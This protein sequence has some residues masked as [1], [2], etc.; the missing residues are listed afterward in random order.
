MNFR[1]RLPSAC[2]S[3]EKVGGVRPETTVKGSAV[4]LVWCCRYCKHEWSVTDE[5][6]DRRTGADRRKKTRNERRRDPG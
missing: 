3:C 6:K 4:Y 2:P 5:H 1:L